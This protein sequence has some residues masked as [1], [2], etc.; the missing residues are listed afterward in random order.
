MKPDQYRHEA[1]VDRVNTTGAV[2]LGLTVGC[3]QCHTHK[4][5]PLSHE[6]YYR[7]Y[8]FFN[9]CDD[10]NNEASTLPVMEEEIFGWTEDQ[11]AQLAE[12]KQLRAQLTDLENQ[13]SAAKSKNLLAHAW[14]W[15]PADIT[16]YRTL[17]M[18][19]F[20][21]QPDGSLLS[22]GKAPPNDTYQITLRTPTE[23]FTAMRLRV[24]PDD[25]LPMKGP[26]LADGN[27]VLT[28]AEIKFREKIFRFT[29]AGA[30]HSQEKYNILDAIDDK[31]T[32]SCWAI[33]SARNEESQS[34]PVHARPPRSGLRAGHSDREGGSYLLARHQQGI[35]HRSVRH[36]H[37]GR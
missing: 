1:I 26:G 11:L 5:D 16:D 3:A 37:L 35:P 34:Q 7:L 2:W 36:R 29:T 25:S 23:R 13:L 14:N 21:R 22:D 31:P 9:Q 12:V 17:G 28:D 10:A 33:T 24:L 20:L 6:D 32:T 19:S 8:A 4:Y 15:K 27:F 18:A 30:D